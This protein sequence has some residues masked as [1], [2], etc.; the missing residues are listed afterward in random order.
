MSSPRICSM[1]PSTPCASTASNVTPSIPGAPSF[2]LAISYASRRVSILQ[3]WTYKP[4]KRQDGS[5]FALTYRFLRRSCKLIGVFVMRLCLPCCWNRYKQQGSFAP[6]ALPG[7]IATTN[8][9]DAL[10]PSALFPC[11]VIGPTFL[12]RFRAGARRVSPVAR[13]VLVVVLSLPPRRNERN[14]SVRLRLLMLSSP[15]DRELDLRG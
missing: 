15:F 13:Y 7:F 2:F 11:V 4:Q 14:A 6:P 3:T 10:S 5:D 12:R 1:K 9:S 8:P